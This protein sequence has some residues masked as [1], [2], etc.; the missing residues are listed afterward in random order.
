MNPVT[1]YSLPAL[2][3][4]AIALTASPFHEVEAGNDSHTSPRKTAVTGYFDWTI[5]P[6]NLGPYI[7]PGTDGDLYLRH[8]PLVGKFTLAG[9][10]VAL[11]AKIQV[12]LSG[13]LDTSGTGVVW[14]PTTLTG[15]VNG[16]KT[17]LFEGN[18]T[19]DEVN[20]VATGRTTLTGR[21]PYEGTKLEFTFQEI[22]PG[23]SN[24]Y[25]LEGE[26]T[27]APRR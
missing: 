17:I 11:E 4:L 1:K 21:G 6:P 20:L 13:E 27:P 3:G 22:G 2:A 16:V 26:L 23:D 19:A 15:V 8:L 5:V 14:A 12:D 7:I 24:T 10:G 9:K 18:G 25:T